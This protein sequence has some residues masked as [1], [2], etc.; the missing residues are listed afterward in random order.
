[1]LLYRWAKALAKLRIEH[2]DYLKYLSLGD[3][4][5]LESSY[6]IIIDEYFLCVLCT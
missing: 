4:F 6:L 2:K 1:M 3:V 5:S